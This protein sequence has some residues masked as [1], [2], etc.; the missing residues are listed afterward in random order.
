VRDGR[1]NK[2]GK[3]KKKGYLYIYATDMWVQKKKG[4]HFLSLLQRFSLII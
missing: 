2:R 4:M 3:K 1:G